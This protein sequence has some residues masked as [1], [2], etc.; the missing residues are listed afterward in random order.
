MTSAYSSHFRFLCLLSV[1]GGCAPS[2]EV[3]CKAIADK[4]TACGQAWATDVPSC[5]QSFEKLEA[6][7]GARAKKVRK[8]VVNASKV[9]DC[10]AS[11]FAM[12]FFLPPDLR[13]GE[14][15]ND[16]P[17][18]AIAATSSTASTPAIME[19]TVQEK[20][21]TG[22]AGAQAVVN[23][24]MKPQSTTATSLMPNASDCAAVFSSED[25]ATAC[26]EHYRELF[27]K[28]ASSI[29]PK[30]GQTV[31]RVFGATTEQLVS[32][33]GAALEF[34][35]GYKRIASNLKPRLTW[36]AFKFV[37]P[38]KT[39][40]MAFDGLVYVNGHWRMF[41]KPFRLVK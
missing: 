7:D 4:A 22:A 2:P 1:L 36:Y 38:G 29:A 9:S 10:G 19:A 8:F 11:L 34:P 20:F 5:V 13:P 35:G 32:G 24:L 3:T 40:G 28:N 18:S 21:P 31:S 30:E 16:P 23:A 39:L 27:S 15:A 6:S 41:P 26:T 25:M 33:R 37:E 17:P 14:T 12:R